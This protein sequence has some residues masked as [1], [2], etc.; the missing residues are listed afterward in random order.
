MTNKDK[1][2]ELKKEL[3][4]YS[5]SDDSRLQAMKDQ[6]EIRELKKKIR[7]KKYVG[8]VQ[9]GKN[10]KVIGK[11]VGVGLKAVGKGFGKFIG[12]PNQKGSK[13]KVKTVEEIM[14]EMP[15]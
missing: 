5:A 10:L 12:E 8:A 3:A 13:K 4:R 7:E 9:V 14:R 11:N 2:T 6:Q 1:I 15:Q